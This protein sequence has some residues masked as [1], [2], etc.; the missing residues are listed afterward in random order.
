MDYQ[1]ISNVVVIPA[2]AASFSFLVEPLRDGLPEGQETVEITVLSDLSYVVGSSSSDTVYIEDAPWDEWRFD[3]F[4]VGE[5]LDPNISGELAD[6]DQDGVTN[7]V[8]QSVVDY[9]EFYLLN[10][11]KP[12][13]GDRSLTST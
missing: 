13:Q 8:P 9:M 1:S 12:A 7:E 3:R 10:Y 5:R 11:F 2:N 4:T 6:P